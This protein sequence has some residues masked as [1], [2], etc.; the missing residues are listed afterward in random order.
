MGTK[1]NQADITIALSARFMISADDTQTCILASSS[2]VGLQRSS[3]KSS[4][5]TKIIFQFL[6]KE[7]ADGLAPRT[8]YSP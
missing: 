2:G 8:G 7:S 1:R 3:G 5:C 4:D 6:R